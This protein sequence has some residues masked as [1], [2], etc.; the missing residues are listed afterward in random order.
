MKRC[1]GRRQR[2]RLTKSGKETIAPYG[3][4]GSASEKF[5]VEKSGQYEIVFV[6]CVFAVR[7]TRFQVRLFAGSPGCGLVLATGIRLRATNLCRS[8][9]V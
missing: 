3:A 7:Q 6:T 8:S 2:R 1:D 4:C 9:S 5:R